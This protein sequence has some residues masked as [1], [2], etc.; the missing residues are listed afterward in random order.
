MFYKKGGTDDLVAYTD[1]DYAD[2]LED[3]KKTSGYVF[4]MS[5]GAV[6]WS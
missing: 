3:R 6:S 1:S 2:D 5:S 4:M